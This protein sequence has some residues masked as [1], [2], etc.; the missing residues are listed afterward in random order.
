L[1]QSLVLTS[2]NHLLALPLLPNSCLLNF[3]L[4][5]N[6]FVSYLSNQVGERTNELRE[7]EQKRLALRDIARQEQALMADAFY[8]VRATPCDVM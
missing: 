4:T 2:V 7:K 8:E 1:V 3:S 5:P 6:F